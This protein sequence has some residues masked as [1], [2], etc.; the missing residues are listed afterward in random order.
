MSKSEDTDDDS[1]P[2]ALT[3]PPEPEP[4][5]ANKLEMRSPSPRPEQKP[6]QSFGQIIWRVLVFL[7]NLVVII[8]ILSALAAGVYFGWPIVYNQYIL[9]VQNHTTQIAQIQQDQQQANTQLSGLATRVAGAATESADQAQVLGGLGS[10]LDTLETEINA[11]TQSLAALEE[12]Q[13]TLQSDKQNQSAELDRQIKL[14]RGMEL[15]S[16]ARLFLYQSNF[17]M[18]RLDIQ[19]ARAILAAVQPGAPEPLATELS[20]VVQRLD[21]CISR[22]PAFPITASDDLD[23]AWQVLLEGPPLSAGLTGTPAS[24]IINPES[25]LTSTAIYAYT[26]TPV[27]DST[28]TPY[29]TTTPTAFS[30]ATPSATPTP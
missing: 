20:D 29:Y 19:N 12:M 6:G 2:L 4:T 15:L 8:V 30:S 11:H 22:L 24:Y 5:P 28:A 13:S 21:L 25:L 10:R 1:Q 3:N 7:F 23:I 14:L 27:V 17:G 26:P 16:R 9:P 18:A